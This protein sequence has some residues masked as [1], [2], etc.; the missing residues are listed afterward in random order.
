M[1][2]QWGYSSTLALTSAFGGGG[3]FTP[4]PGRFTPGKEK[5]YPLSI[6]C[7]FNKKFQSLIM[8]YIEVY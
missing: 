6:S 7:K 4:R 1:K 5:Q 8:K 3:W 2:T